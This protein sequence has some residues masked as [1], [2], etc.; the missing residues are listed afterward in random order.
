MVVWNVHGEKVSVSNFLFVFSHAWWWR[1]LPTTVR[2]W[3]QLYRCSSMSAMAN[4][5]GANHSASPTCQVSSEIVNVN[6][7]FETIHVYIRM[8]KVFFFKSALDVVTVLP[9]SKLIS[10]SLIE[11]RDKV[12]IT[13]HT[14][15]LGLCWPLFL[16]FSLQRK[17]CCGLKGNLPLTITLTPANCLFCKASLVASPLFFMPWLD[18]HEVFLIQIF[19]YPWKFDYI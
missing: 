11:S 8:S 4:A 3:A 12:L 6:K 9:A 2:L 7:A 18:L 16:S 5:K 10:K 19:L 14:S 17:H 15:P 1:C 13:L